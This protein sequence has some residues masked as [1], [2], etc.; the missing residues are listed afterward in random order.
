[1]AMLK[2]TNLSVSYGHVR[3]LKNVHVEAGE[4]LKTANAN[5]LR[6]EHD[7]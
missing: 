4:R 5:F 2:V 7:H 3:A 1:M 6:S